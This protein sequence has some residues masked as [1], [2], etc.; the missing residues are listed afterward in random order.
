VEISTD[1][2]PEKGV[3]PTQNVSLIVLLKTGFL[4]SIWFCRSSYFKLV[5]IHQLT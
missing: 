1:M 2:Y 3:N 5:T 4:V